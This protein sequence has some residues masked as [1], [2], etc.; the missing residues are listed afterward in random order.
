[1]QAELFTYGTIVTLAFFHTV[2]GPDH[3]L[4]FIA[5]SRNAG[6][7]TRKTAG[8]T[9]ICGL[10]HVLSSVII[11][12]S[13]L[14]FGIAIYKLEAIQS[15]RSDIAAWL[16]M[17][18]GAGYVLWGYYLKRR[19][20]HHHGHGHSH[21]Y[22]YSHESSATSKE[23]KK[24]L[25]PWVL[26]TIFVFGPC[27]VLIPMLMYYAAQNNMSG[28][29]TATILFGVTTI[30]TMLVIVLLTLRGIK[31]IRLPFLEHHSHTVAGI[32]IL[33]SGAGIKFLGL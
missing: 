12:L 22:G 19:H 20:P 15:H 1:M 9:I 29:V 11:G 24:S 28:M 30:A 33:L 3:Y 7:S 2:V 8:L 17:I 13:G 16:L 6:W 27:E 5:M 18:F 10:G 31:L 14:A 4:P 23:G 32:I 26:F 21:G 25:T